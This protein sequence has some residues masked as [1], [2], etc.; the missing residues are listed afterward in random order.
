MSTALNP[1]L[2]T[3]AAQRITLRGEV[4]P[5]RGPQ[6]RELGIIEDGGVLF[7]GGKITAVGTT[8]ALRKH[9]KD[10]DEIDCTGKLILPGFVDSH[11]HPVFGAPRLIDFEKRI[12]GAS[13][14]EIAAA[15]G[16]IR[17]SIRG[18]RESSVEQLDAHVLRALEEM[19]S[20]GTTT[21]EAKSG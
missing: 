10:A 9:A 18:V 4:A 13:Y 16:G 11:T 21:V 15:G 19:D 6:M 17:A 14:E 2:L 20:Y 3:H 5:R 12:A 8:D 7:A 1:V